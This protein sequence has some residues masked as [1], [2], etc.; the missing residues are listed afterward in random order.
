MSSGILSSDEAN[1]TNSVVSDLTNVI[2]DLKSTGLTENTEGKV[3]DILSEINSLIETFNSLGLRTLGLQQLTNS[4]SSILEESL[5][6]SSYE[7]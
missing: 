2:N 5:P 7:S 1:Q 6:Q 3:R 4:I